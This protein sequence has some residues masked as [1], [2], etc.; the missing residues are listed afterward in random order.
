MSIKKYDD[1]TASEIKKE[2]KDLGVK[3]VS[4]IKK[5]LYEQYEGAMDKEEAVE[6]VEVVENVEEIET[7]KVVKPKRIRE[8]EPSELVEVRSITRGG[9]TYVSKKT[10]LKVTWGEYGDVEYLEFAELLTMRSHSR[11]FLEKPLVVI[12]DVDVAA[13]LNLTRLY[14]GLLT[15]EEVEGFLAMP[16]EDIEEQLDNLPDGSISLIKDTARETVGKTFNDIRK[17]KLLEEKLNIGLSY[18]ID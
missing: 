6:E 8:I 11:N 10:G 14:E 7:P 3:P 13:K 12:G 15:A 9:L 16:L 4:N 1:I 5:E 2:L 17:I 18:L